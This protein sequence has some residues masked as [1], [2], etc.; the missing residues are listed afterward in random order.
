MSQT[1]QQRTIISELID[2]TLRN[3]AKQLIDEFEKTKY[4]DRVARFEELTGEIVQDGRKTKAQA[5]YRN[6]KAEAQVKK[7]RG[8]NRIGKKQ[9]IPHSPLMMKSGRRKASK[10]FQTA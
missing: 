8:V 10:H 2:D 3:T 4:S 6:R 7:V 9:Y 5:A 1:V